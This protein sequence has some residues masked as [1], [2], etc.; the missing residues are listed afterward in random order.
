MFELR[1]SVSELRCSDVNMFHL[2]WRGVLGQSRFANLLRGGDHS[3]NR[4]YVC[5]D[6]L[7]FAGKSYL[8]VDSNTDLVWLW[9]LPVAHTPNVDVHEV[10][11]AIVPYSSAMQPQGCVTQLRRRNPT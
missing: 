8:A 3:V 1:C 10:R 7:E 4:N 9:A 5:E 2:L 6:E 11:A